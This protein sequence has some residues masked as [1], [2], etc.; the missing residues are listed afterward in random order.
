MSRIGKQPIALPE[1]VTVTVN[2]ANEV[3]VKGPKGSLTQA[4]DKDIKVEQA[5][6]Q[7]QVV[8]PT[9]QLRHRA[10][11]GLYRSI[12]ANMVKG[13]TEGYTRKLELVGVGYKAVNQGK[14]R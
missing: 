6:G 12:V 1:G 8:R 2:A 9:E 10:M 3:T 4:I 7:L 13:V 5:D 11:H 14:I